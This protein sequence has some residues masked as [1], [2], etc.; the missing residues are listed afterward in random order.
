MNRS[1]VWKSLGL[2]AMALAL[3]ACG[4]SSSADPTFAQT[5]QGPVKGTAAN[6]VV[7]FLGVPYA[8]PPTGAL[9]WKPPAPALARAAVL[10]AKAPGAQCLQAGPPSAFAATGSEDCLYL[11]IYR[12]EAAPAAP[13]PVIVGIHG[14]GFVLGSSA[15]MNGTSLA[16]N[17]NVILVSINYRLS[18]LGFLAHPALTAEDTATRASGNY[19]LMDQ[20][21]ALAWV[22]QNIAAFGGDPSNVTLTGG[23]A[24][25]LSV[26]TH[27]VSPMSAGL[28]AK[29]APQSGG[30]SRLQA[31]LAQSEAAGTAFTAPWNCNSAG[32]NAQVA[33]CLR[34][35]PAATTLIGA[36]PPPQSGTGNL[37]SWLPIIDGKFLTTSTSIAFASGNFQKVPL[38]TGVVDDEGT[39]FV[40][41]AFGQ[42][43]ITAATYEPVGI[44]G[45]LGLANP[46][47]VSARYPLASYPSPNQALA[48]VY[49]DFRV[50][51]GI[52]QDTDSIA[53]ALPAG[54]KAYV[55]QFSEKTPYMDATSLASR[56]PP[57]TNITYGAFHGADVPYWFDQMTAN[58]T[59]AQLQLAQ[60]M[61]KS[62]ANFARTGNPNVDGTL[63]LWQPYSASQ[64]GVLNLTHAAS[65]ANVDAYGA[66]Q[67]SYWYGQPPSTR[68]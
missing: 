3:T 68:L 66:H 42:A 43:P 53:S 40:S 14:G 4:G 44:A 65:T 17:N 51:C 45:F 25:G 60:T 1:I 6:G 26:F 12:P 46:A 8:A 54:A 59:T 9:R 41:A 22:K 55:Y 62:F 16:K 64:R 18:A 2:A 7:Q 57:N 50:T 47:A 33:A 38:M 27:M 15:F 19:G 20:N 49:G 23:S 58:P 37:S 29:A 11:N 34:S 35:L 61:S 56:L 13:L 21:A 39:F 28:F 5:Q 24:G 67:C 63:P 36:L 31:T 10:D 30:F 32:T 48:R 52:L